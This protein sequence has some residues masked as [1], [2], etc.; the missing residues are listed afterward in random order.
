MRIVASSAAHSSAELL[1]SVPIPYTPRPSAHPSLGIGFAFSG[2][3]DV[4]TTTKR[5]G[6]HRTFSEAPSAQPANKRLGGSGLSR[7]V[8]I[9]LHF[10]FPRRPPCMEAE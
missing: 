5:E 4:L 9:R 3:L 1:W 8:V 10:E 6:A 2:R 7:Q